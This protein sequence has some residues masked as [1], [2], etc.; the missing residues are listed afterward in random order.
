[1]VLGSG[2]GVLLFP[3]SGGQKKWEENQT[4]LCSPVDNLQVRGD[5]EIRIPSVDEIS[6]T[7]GNGFLSLSSPT[8]V[9]G[10]SGSFVR[11]NAVR[12][13]FYSQ[14]FEVD[15]VVESYQTWVSQ[16]EYLL[17]QRTIIEP[18]VNASTKWDSQF[19]AVK[20]SK[21][22]N[23]VYLYRVQKSL[24]DVL[25]NLSDISFFNAKERDLMSKNIKTP[26]VSVTLT[27]DTKRCSL[28]EA[29]ENIGKEFDRWISN[30]RKEFGRITI[31][32]RTWEAFQNGYP[33]V[34][35]ILLFHDM[36]FNVFRY[37]SKLRI[38][39]KAAFSEHW[40]SYVDVQALSNIKTSVRYITKYITKDLFSE[41]A[42][43]TLAMLWLFRKRSFSMSRDFES[44]VRR[45]DSPM[46]NS[47]QVSLSGE[48]VSEI[49]WHFIGIFS[50][51]DLKINEKVWS[52]QIP[53]ENV[54][55]LIPF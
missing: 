53:K 24:S 51:Y 45:L 52:I 13:L 42:T 17:L 21:R 46:H 8:Q 39:E 22:G 50:S 23:D 25:D 47:Y 38:R 29:W 32:I 31:I 2:G 20:C 55:D 49:V 1:M 33:H 7:R 18:S 16:D 14:I 34:N 15:D 10:V 36:D 41:K 43:L 35:A 3:R 26:L 37:R 19:I 4:T 40:H 48:K 27:Y 28:Y 11:L 6:S 30:L 12:N 44:M 54:S 9:G 5:A